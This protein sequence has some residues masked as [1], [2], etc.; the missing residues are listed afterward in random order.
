M[1][2]TSLTFS[3]GG[4]P[5][6]SARGCQQ[7][8]R[9]LKTGELKRTIDGRL[10]YIGTERH[11]KYQSTI[12]CNDKRSFAHEGFWRGAEVKIGCIQRLWQ[13]YDKKNSLRT[14]LLERSPVGGSVFVIDMDGKT[15]PIEMVKGRIIKFK[16]EPAQNEGYFASYRPELTMVVTDFFLH[17]DEWGME[18]G[19][20]LDLE[21]V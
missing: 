19:W 1:K 12:Y 7:I 4:F 15:I 6:F 2:E 11:H 18:S 9:P 5:P 21:E 17:T 3:I 10:I 20:Q 16:D 14:L 13:K 8:L